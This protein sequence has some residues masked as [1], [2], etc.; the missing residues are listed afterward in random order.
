[1]ARG[2]FGKDRC[3]RS[4]LGK[5]TR[6]GSGSRCAQ[7]RRENRQRVG[8]VEGRSED[9]HRQSPRC[10]WEA[11]PS[12]RRRVENKVRWTNRS[13]WREGKQCC[14]ARGCSKNP[15]LKNP[16]EQNHSNDRANGW[17]QR[18]RTSGKRARRWD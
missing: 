7:S 18:R 1:C 15:E 13:V 9:M 14:A 3:G 10:G 16:G 17:R 5:E 6:E 2:A 11:A 8:D 12:N 4:R